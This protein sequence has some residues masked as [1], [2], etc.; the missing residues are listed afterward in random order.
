[1]KR[2]WAWP[3]W[4][5]SA[6][7][8]LAAAVLGFGW[9][10]RPDMSRPL[11]VYSP[12][13]VAQAELSRRLDDHPQQAQGVPLDVDYH[14]DPASPPAWTPK[15]QSPVLQRL[16]QRGLLPPVAQRTGPEP[17][18]LT[19]EQ[20]G[21]YGGT[22]LTAS[23]SDRYIFTSLMGR[24][25]SNV[26]LLRWSPLG[27]PIVPN[28]ARSYEVSP[29]YREFTFHLRRGV[30]WSDGE[31][32]TSG[33]I[34]YWWR[35]EVNDDVLTNKGARMPQF[36]KIADTTG[37]IDAPDEYTVR[38]R[39]ARPNG[40]FLARLATSAGS[41]MAN[42]PRHYLSRYH[43]KLGQPELIRQS[44]DARGLPSPQALYETL[45]EPN[46]PE[47][48]RM[49]P[50]VY[51]AYKPNPP[52]S[53]VR[54]PYYWAVDVR[55]NQLPYIDRIQ[56]EVKSWEMLGASGATAAYPL[57]ELDWSQYSLAAAE[58][59]KRGLRLLPWRRADGGSFAIAVNINRYVPPADEDPQEHRQAA[60]KARVLA[61]KRFRQALS[62]AIDR[63]A[64]I[65]A[66]Y[67]GNAQASQ[68]APGPESPFYDE[69]SYTAYTQFNPAAAGA[70]LDDMGLTR[71][72]YE[73]FRTF[74]DGTRMTLLLTF[75]HPTLADGAQFIVADWKRIGVRV[76]PLLQGDR[77]YYS[78]KANL[79]HDLAMFPGHNTY[80]PMITAR[81]FVP[82]GGESNFALGHA[83][84]YV[85]GG[86]YGSPRS[87]NS[88]CIEPPPGSDVRQAIE[89]YERLAE[90]GDQASQI[91]MFRRIMR[92]ASENVWTINVASSPPIIA[93]VREDFGNVPRQLV[94]SFDFISP[95]NAY[96]ERFFLSGAADSA[97]AI[98]QIEQQILA[99]TPPPEA[100]KAQPTQPSVLSAILRWALLGM[101][102][103]LVAMAVL[104]HPYI[105]RRLAI[106]VP[107]LLVISVI[108]FAIIQLPPEDYLTARMMELQRTGDGADVARADELRRMFHL[109]APQVERYARW[110]GLA[111]FATFDEKDKGLLQGDLGRSMETGAKV[112]QIVG[113]R[114]LLTVAISF[115][116]IL[117][118]W[119]LALP[120]GIY[121]AV[122]QY[123]PGDYAVT[124]VGFVGMCVPPFL[125]ALIL[126]FVAR[127]WFNV[128]ASGLF[129]GQYA[130]QPEWSWPKVMDLLKHIWVPVVVLGVGG[131]AG[132][133]RVMRGNLLDELRKPYVVAARARGVRPGKLLL[134]YPVRLA[135]NPFISGIGHLFPALVSG[136]AIVAIVLSLPTVG[137]LLLRALMMEDMYLAGSMLM[138]LSLL[139]VVGTLVSDLLL[140]WLDP[141]IRFHRGRP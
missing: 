115:G 119:A 41:D 121:S 64:I 30:R 140:L 50:W 33:D 10:M 52:Y 103:G 99:V 76:I 21:S 2:R 57:M 19:A 42:S 32:F 24:R 49:W 85:S 83:A 73:G 126:M 55:G 133:I 105:G 67:S 12:A 66:E 74:A 129:S 7:A 81:C 75:V 46:N 89:L 128:D 138:V 72:D 77:L 137:P 130:V 51:R 120:V 92:L 37:E 13:Q 104:R 110:M 25:M 40:L 127:E 61:D 95:G 62:L 22:W 43:P 94:S 102:A 82:V 100:P 59:P 78:Q 122:R 27:Y 31:P 107:T 17:L 114:I 38:F 132:M 65:Q 112:D 54:N 124:L 86:L 79:Q 113:D 35:H 47:H 3:V 1:M 93:V 87:R 28:L 23:F 34:L 45:K 116:T 53:F 44:L 106:M 14:F 88:D 6:A 96:P 118:T 125:L 136:G 9:L 60:N 97:G 20:I 15:G 4:F 48:P 69:Q 134:K 70:L 84:W 108:V 135:L 141:R 11:P 111:W 91:E 63:Q 101:A 139:A 29:D 98:E 71:R 26:G 109:D 36:M 39:F 16:C 117:F 80:L 131:A 5:L 8:A 56:Y 68:V 90:V 58:A 18:V 123:S